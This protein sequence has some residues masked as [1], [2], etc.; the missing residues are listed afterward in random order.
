MGEYNRT[1]LNASILS[2][3]NKLQLLLSCAAFSPR[4]SAT[5]KSDD[6]EGNYI[7]PAELLKTASAVELFLFDAAHA[8]W[9][10]LLLNLDKPA[11]SRVS[12]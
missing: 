1:A 10:Y 2:I 6:A 11:R 7:P 4:Q 8:R 12:V 3:K 9:S 5:G